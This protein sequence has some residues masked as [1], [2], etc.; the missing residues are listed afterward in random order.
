MDQIYIDR[1]KAT[2]ALIEKDEDEYAGS[3]FDMS[4]WVTPPEDTSVPAFCNTTMCF[5]GWAMVQEIGSM[6]A[7]IE[8]AVKLIDTEWGSEE[9]DTTAWVAD[10]EGHAQRYLGFSDREA[11]HIFYRTSIS[12]AHDLKQRIVDVLEEVIWPG[13][14][15]Y[16]IDEPG[17]WRYGT[18]PERIYYWK[19]VMDD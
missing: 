17:G 14:E 19:Q 3:H 18:D 4:S 6:E 16:K 8:R 5:A 1:I 13:F 12:T 11:Q 10:V 7:F 9:Y 2:I 15:I